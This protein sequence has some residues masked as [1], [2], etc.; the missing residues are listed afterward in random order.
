[1]RDGR[2]AVERI[3][4]ALICALAVSAVWLIGQT[5]LISPRQEA[6]QSPYSA[7]AETAVHAAAQPVTAAVSMSGGFRCAVQYDSA[8]AA[9]IVAAFE[10]V[11]KEAL[12]SAAE[13]EP[14][15][16]EQLRAALMRESLFLEYAAEL[17]LELIA[18]WFGTESR[19]EDSAL[20]LVISRAENG[21]VELLYMRADGA[22]FS[23]RSSAS[24]TGFEQAALG[25]TANDGRFA[26]ELSEA[27]SAFGAYNI[28]MQQQ[29]SA[30]TLLVGL[31]AGAEM[32]TSAAAAFDI[33]ENTDFQ[34]TESD[35][36]V[37]YVEGD[38]VLRLTSGGRLSV[39]RTE[40]SDRLSLDEDAGPVQV[41]EAA[42][43]LVEATAGACS[44]LAD[45][46]LTALEKTENG[47]TLRFGYFVEAT[48]LVATG[49]GDAAVIVFENGML[50]YA[51]I[52]F[53]SC[54][55]TGES[56]VLLPELLAAAA[57]GDGEGIALRYVDRGG[58]IVA[59]EWTVK[60]VSGT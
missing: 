49:S 24:G 4:T 60:A 3:K 12:G 46:Q 30:Q 22:A 17:P 20:R 21:S 11:L 28:V 31:P 57:A 35:G 47:W 59:A 38:F 36:T 50:S 26:W 27:Y 10:N 58:E 41:V 13:P 16:E 45:V 2:G 8:A 18:A 32:I 25:C 33:N 43:R 23:C 55:G 6:A 53:L 56:T 52:E 42:R 44:G 48:E 40:Q 15:A 9:D 29:R 37:V 19:L 1:M 14:I 39:R 5:G 34:Y 7:D 51:G 54:T